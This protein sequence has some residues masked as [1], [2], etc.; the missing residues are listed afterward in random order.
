M[1]KQLSN[2]DRIKFPFPYMLRAVPEIILRGGWAAFFFRPLHPQDTHRVTAPRPSGHASALINHRPTMDQILLDPQD[3]LPPPTHR[4]CQQNTLPPPPQD[5]KVSAVHTPLRIISGTALSANSRSCTMDC[6]EGE[7]HIQFRSKL[8]Q[9]R[10]GLNSFQGWNTCWD[11]APGCHG[12]YNS[13]Q[14]SGIVGAS[15]YLFSYLISTYKLWWVKKEHKVHGQST[16]ASWSTLLFQC[17]FQTV[18]FVKPSPPTF[19]FTAVLN[20]TK[21]GACM[22]YAFNSGDR[23]GWQV[24]L[25]CLQQTGWGFGPTTLFVF[26]KVF[27]KMNPFRRKFLWSIQLMWKASYISYKAGSLASLCSSSDWLVVWLSLGAVNCGVSIRCFLGLPCLYTWWSIRFD[28][29]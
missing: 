3:K 22:E 18:L 29:W 27:Q 24:L 9:G 6:T 11:F 21:V 13:N 16:A 10:R 23:W 14:V 7:V 19:V 2:A 12:L 1:W 20:F 26:P 4:T 17:P 8:L 28:C 15:R 25:S 5:K